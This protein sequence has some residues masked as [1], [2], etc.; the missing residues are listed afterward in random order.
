MKTPEHIE[1]AVAI[2]TGT[3]QEVARTITTLEPRQLADKQKQFRKKYSKKLEKKEKRKQ[4]G[5]NIELE[6]TKKHL[7]NLQRK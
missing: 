5:K 4:N 3:I 2:L 1:Q 6:K 7:N